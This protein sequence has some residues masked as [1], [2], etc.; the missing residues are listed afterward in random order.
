MKLDHTKKKHDN[1]NK[2]ICEFNFYKN[3]FDILG[4][5]QSLST[6][7]F[8]QD[9]DT[10]ISQ[11]YITKILIKKPVSIISSQIIKRP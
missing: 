10:T 6:T 9:L 11:N 2:N 7:L 4:G 8:F 1:K 5:S 3:Y